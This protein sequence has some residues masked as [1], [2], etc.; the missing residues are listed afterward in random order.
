MTKPA[1]RSLLRAALAPW[2][3]LRELRRIDS[4]AALRL[5]P[6]PFLYA[7]RYGDKSSGSC[8]HGVA[9]TQPCRRCVEVFDLNVRHYLAGEEF[10]AP[11]YWGAA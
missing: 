8:R 11:Y 6:D 10:E 9:N 5:A 1:P 7:N 2:R 3:M 4:V